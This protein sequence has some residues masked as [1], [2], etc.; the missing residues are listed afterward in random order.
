MAQ[1]ALKKLEEEC[2]SYPWDRVF[3]IPLDP[4]D[5]A[6]RVLYSDPL[7]LND[8]RDCVYESFEM[9]VWGTA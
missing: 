8:M 1:Q 2:G 6:Y 3:I 4:A 9:P 7:D 5:G